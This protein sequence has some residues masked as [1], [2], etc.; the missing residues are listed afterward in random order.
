M[1]SCVILI[2]AL[3]SVAQA[4]D[5]TTGRSRLLV[6]AINF[7]DYA[8]SFQSCQVLHETNERIQQFVVFRLCPKA[9][10]NHAESKWWSAFLFGDYAVPLGDDSV[11]HPQ[12]VPDETCRDEY[13]VPLEKYLSIVAPHQKKIQDKICRDCKWFCNNSTWE[14]ESSKCTSCNH[15]CLFI[16]HMG[17][18]GYRDA[19]A[20]MH[21]EMIYDYDQNVVQHVLYAGPM[22]AGQEGSQIKIG[23]FLDEHCTKPDPMNRRIDDLLPSATGNYVSWLS[24][25]LLRSVYENDEIPC[26]DPNTLKTNEVCESLYETNTKIALVAAGVTVVQV[27]A[28]VISLGLAA[29]LIRALWSKRVQSRQPTSDGMESVEMCQG[30]KWN[31]LDSIDLTYISELQ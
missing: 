8:I 12:P 17:Y 14:K 1:V 29:V 5:S 19:T 22:C 25:P 18:N 10:N 3:V 9:M 15:T 20:Y 11:A 31:N 16:E 13:A 4:W 6:P 7:E 24:Y 2:L 28:I 30:T 26:R 27:G 21:C 23:V